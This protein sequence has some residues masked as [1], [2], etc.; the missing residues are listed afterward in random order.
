MTP[1]TQVALAVGSVIAMGFIAGC[2]SHPP[3]VDCDK[4]LLPINAPAPKTTDGGARKPT[5]PAPSSDSSH[6]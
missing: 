3:K 6:E 5:A 4:H 2:R 1:R